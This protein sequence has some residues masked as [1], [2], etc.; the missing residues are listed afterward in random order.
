M[1]SERF[2]KGDRG[3]DHPLNPAEFG[4]PPEVRILEQQ[5]ERLLLC[6]VPLSLVDRGEVAVDE[7]IITDTARLMDEEPRN[8]R[9]NGQITPVYLVQVIDNSNIT[10]PSIFLCDGYHRTEIQERKGS[11]FIYGTIAL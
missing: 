6:E 5:D 2:R 7:K 10:A 11:E 4:L 3:G 1:A 9:Y 8:R